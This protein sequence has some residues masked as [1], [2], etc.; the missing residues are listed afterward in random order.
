[1]WMCVL[2]HLSELLWKCPVG[3]VLELLFFG[4]GDYIPWLKLP[5][6]REVLF[7]SFVNYPQ[8]KQK[9]WKE[10]CVPHIGKQNL[11]K[12]DLNIFSKYWCHYQLFQTHWSVFFFP[13]SI[14]LWILRKIIRVYFHSWLK[15]YRL[16]YKR[17]ME[18]FLINTVELS[19]RIIGFKKIILN[20]LKL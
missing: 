18:N 10:K 19:C 12:K 14:C 13:C 2:K 6:R 4:F 16:T 1:M 7:F 15:L 9:W 17:T 11:R 3:K 20:V 8:W 5:S